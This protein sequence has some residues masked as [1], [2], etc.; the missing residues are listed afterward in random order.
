MKNNWFYSKDRKSILIEL[1]NKNLGK[2]YTTIDSDQFE[3]VNQF[4]TTWFVGYKKGHIDGVKT[5]IQK[6]KIRK[7]V[8]LH[9]LIMNPI[10]GM[11]VDHIDGDTLNNKLSNLRVL[12]AKENATNLSS[13]SKNKSGFTNIYFDHGKYRVRISNINFGS[14]SSIN[15]ALIVRDKNIKNIFPLRER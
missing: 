12:T 15:K 8:W 13:V 2:L 10:E 5:K 9:R 6:N 7:N 3:L 14:Y 1:H 11:V 4:N